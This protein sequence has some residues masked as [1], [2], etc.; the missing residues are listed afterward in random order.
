MLRF[1]RMFREQ[2]RRLNASWILSITKL[3]IIAVKAYGFYMKKKNWNEFLLKFS[4]IFS[5]KSEESET[6]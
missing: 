1:V 4:S 6:D 3:Q 5:Y 2:A